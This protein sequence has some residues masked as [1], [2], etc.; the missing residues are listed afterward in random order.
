MAKYR[1]ILLLAFKI[2]I[3]SSISIYIAQVRAI[4]GHILYLAENMI[5]ATGDTHC[6]WNG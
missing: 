5:F 2:G 4:W 1:K 6:G 3:G